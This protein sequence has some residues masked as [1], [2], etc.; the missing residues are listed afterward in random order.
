[1]KDR[2]AYY[3]ADSA[4][5]PSVISTAVDGKN[6]L[7]VGH[8]LTGLDLPFAKGAYIVDNSKQ[9]RLMRLKGDADCSSE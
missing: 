5:L 8:S 3:F 4:V 2:Q 7:R 1:M 6:T 9:K